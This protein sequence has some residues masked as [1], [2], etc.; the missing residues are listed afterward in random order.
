MLGWK[1]VVTVPS[2]ALEPLAGVKLNDAVTGTYAADQ[3]TGKPAS[4]PEA[5]HPAV[6]GAGQLT[7]A[8]IE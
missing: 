8:V 6:P 7:V 4:W 2:A 3:T 5:G 1:D